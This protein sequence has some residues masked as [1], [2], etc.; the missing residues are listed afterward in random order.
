MVAGGVLLLLC[1]VSALSFRAWFTSWVFVLP[2]VLSAVLVAGA[3]VLGKRFGVPPGATAFGV[4]ILISL[5]GAAFFYG[6]PTPAVLQD[7]IVGAARSPKALLTAVSPAG[8]S[9]EL[10]VFPYL[11]VALCTYIAFF[12][13]LRG[14]KGAPLVGPFLILVVGVLFSADHRIQSGWLAVGLGALTL[15]YLCVEN[16]LVD[17]SRLV[18]VVGLAGAAVPLVLAVVVAAGSVFLAPDSFFDDRSSLR[19]AVAPPIE[20]QN[21]RTPLA[22]YK[23]QLDPVV[24]GDVVYEVRGTDLVDQPIRL[25]SLDTYDGN[26]WSVRNGIAS[27]VPVANDFEDLVY[28]TPTDEATESVRSTQFTIRDFGAWESGVGWLPT[29]G[30]TQ[31]MNW[32]VESAR[33]LGRGEAGGIRVD[34]VGGNLLATAVEGAGAGGT[35]LDYTTVSV[36]GGVWSD[37]VGSESI[38]TAIIDRTPATVARDVVPAENQERY[39]S[40][41]TAIVGQQTSP[42][43]Q[44]VALSDALRTEQAAASSSQPGLGKRPVFDRTAASGHALFRT[45]QLLL[46]HPSEYQGT[47]EQYGSALALLARSIDIPA[48]VVVGYRVDESH[49]VA[50]RDASTDAAAGAGAQTAELRIGD[51]DV[52]VE[53][54]FQDLGWVAFPAGPDSNV[55]SEADAERATAPETQELSGVNPGQF[56]REDV[57][58]FGEAAVEELE[59]FQLNPPEE[60]DDLE[61]TGLS[62]FV[63]GLLTFLFVVLILLL[64]PFLIVAF[65]RRR[66]HRNRTRGDASNQIAGAWKQFGADSQD[67][68]I[69][70]PPNRSAHDVATEMTE[71]PAA[72]IIAELAQIIDRAAF[73]ANEPETTDASAAWDHIES[74]QRSRVD[75]YG[76]VAAVKQQLNVASVRSTMEV[77]RQ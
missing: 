24:A 14:W 5:V 73:A 20:V 21:M 35:Q 53:V 48:R 43:L 23:A 13:L 76:K 54:A 62:T 57:S 36:D 63:K 10:L 68:N 64:I 72:A 52:W 16:D 50:N 38:A 30:A 69:A 22:S 3:M 2:V 56:D 29:T 28:R 45:D 44:M 49:L 11:L 17:P 1:I 67:W 59:P 26:V 37:S 32:S 33:S 70:V 58:E 34:P 71:D 75:S 77:S 51:V 60:E 9:N 61:S 55:L 27:F 8:P 46:S 19:R 42:F 12:A 31:S 47:G 65:K 15:L 7:F 74:I 6:L 40:L 4:G 66:A 18:S 41:A 39:R 25:A